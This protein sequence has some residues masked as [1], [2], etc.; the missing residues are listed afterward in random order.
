MKNEKWSHK[1]IEPVRRPYLNRLDKI[2]T[3]RK[4]EVNLY[5]CF[6]WTAT[7]FVDF[8]AFLESFSF[9]LAEVTISSW[10]GGAE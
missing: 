6:V 2:E 4:V 10:E 5:L 7:V 9:E 3:K 1:K 8:A